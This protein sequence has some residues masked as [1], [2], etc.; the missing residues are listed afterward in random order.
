MLKNYFWFIL[1]ALLLSACAGPASRV[2]L[3]DVEPIVPVVTGPAP[4]QTAGSLWTESR[5]GLFVDMKG[6]TVGDIITVVIIESASASKE[7]TTETDRTSSM[8]A[9][10]SNI[11]GLEK[12][13]GELGNSSIDPSALVNATATNDFSG[14]G[15]TERSENLVATLTT[16]IVEVLPNDNFKIE[17]NKTVTVNNEMQIVK[18]TGIIRSAD[19][20]PQNI[21]DSKNILNARIAYIGEGVISDKQQQGWLVRALDQVWPF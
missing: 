3:N 8:S 15:K 12:Y 7:A 6:K 11:F 18:L 19:V 1:I 10:I 2:D 4:P 21:V 16:Q 17:G 5:G 9:G 20:S 13:I 14:G